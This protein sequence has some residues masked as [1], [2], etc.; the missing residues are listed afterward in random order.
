MASFLGPAVGPS[1]KVTSL[2]GAPRQP[3]AGA[4]SKEERKPGKRKEKGDFCRFFTFFVRFCV[5]CDFLRFR[6]FFACFLRLRA[7]FGME[8]GTTKGHSMGSPNSKLYH[9]SPINMRL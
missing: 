3:L 1:A 7:D 9:S 8:G 5:F 6:V 4:G 2:P